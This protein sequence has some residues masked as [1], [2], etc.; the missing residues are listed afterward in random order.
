[1]NV[2]REFMTFT[3][4]KGQLKNF[5]LLLTLTSFLY[6]SIYTIIT[7]IMYQVQVP[8]FFYIVMYVVVLVSAYVYML[9]LYQFYKTKREL[10]K[11]VDLKAC[12]VPVFLTQSIFYVLMVGGS[13]LSY[14]FMVQSSLQWMQYVLIPVLILLLILYV[15][16][17]IFAIFTI[18]DGERQVFT[19]LKTSLQKIVK[20]YQSIFYSLAIVFIIALIYHGCMDLFFGFH[21]SFIP[22]SAVVDIMTRSNP[23]LMVFELLGSVLD[24]IRI[25]LPILLSLGYGFFMCVVLSVYYMVLLCIYDENI[26]I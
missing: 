15:P 14:F 19:I 12:R 13:L 16:W 2:L 11:E 5:V 6:C 9:V 4:L 1:M 10:K 17:Q 23:F 3:N 22:T 21:S 8:A 20:H 18:L 25:A 26:K 24:N 7:N